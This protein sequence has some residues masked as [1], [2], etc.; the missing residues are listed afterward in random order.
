MK[1]RLL[2]ITTIIV[3]LSVLISFFIISGFSYETNP[4]GNIESINNRESLKEV[5][6]ANTACSVHWRVNLYEMW[7]NSTYDFKNDPV[8]Q[9]CLQWLEFEE[10]A[11]TRYHTNLDQIKAILEYCI[12]SKDLVGTE[13]LSY[14]N[15]T[16][17]IDTVN[18]EWQALTTIRK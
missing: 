5:V 1:T 9:E 18:C 3:G 15:N 6:W 12:D 14:S 17:Y 16:H 8:F 10:Y 4:R 7:D 11:N 13:E 2:M